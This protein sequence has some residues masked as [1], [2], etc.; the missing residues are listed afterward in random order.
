MM[1]RNPT[2]SFGDLARS[3]GGQSWSSP[4]MSPF[5]PD[6]QKYGVVARVS[7]RLR[8]LTHLAGRRITDLITVNG[9]RVQ[10]DGGGWGGLIRASSN[11]PPNLVVVCESMT[12]YDELYQIF[13]ALD[14]VLRVEPSVG[15][16]YDQ[17]LA[18]IE[19]GADI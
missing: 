2:R 11:T 10:L 14:R 8:T 12:S 3:L 18:P 17:R 15:G 19:G 1:D 16:D 4:T 5:C 7:E 9:V 6:D 13:T